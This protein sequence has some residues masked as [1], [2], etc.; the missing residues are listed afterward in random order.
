MTEKACGLGLVTKTA[1]NNFC[2][3]AILET[4][5]TGFHIPLHLRALRQ[6]TTQRKVVDDDGEWHLGFKQVYTQKMRNIL[7]SC[8]CNK[9]WTVCV[10]PQDT[11]QGR[12]NVTFFSHL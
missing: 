10:K 3:A 6:H 7:W 4:G 1:N 11:Q 5:Q 9:K 8:K 12:R 2:M